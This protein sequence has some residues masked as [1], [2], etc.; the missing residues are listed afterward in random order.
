MREDKVKQLEKKCMKIREMI[1]DEIYNVGSGHV[2]GSFSAVEALVVLY[3]EIM[4]IDP[5]NP[6]MKGRDRFVLSKGHAGPAL[7]AVLADRGYFEESL[8]RTLNKPDTIL[9]SH[10]DM[11]KTPGIDMT[12]GSLGQGISCAVGMAYASKLAE[13]NAY[14]YVMVGDGECQEGQVWEAALS[15]ANLGLNNLIV[16]ID[17]NKIQLD[18]DLT[19][20][21]DM[22]NL[23]GKWREFGFNVKSIDG[24]NVSEICE[25]IIE[26]KKCKD[27]PSAIL[28][29]TIKG[30]GVSFIE[31]MGYKN[32][33]M[34][35]DDNLRNKAIREIKGESFNGQ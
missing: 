27:K 24:H 7:Y 11:N 26:C 6:R 1:I 22:G 30:K 5:Y 28:L 32:H 21:V 14:I 35:I 3:N 4:N 29:N 12:T 9:P 25:S 18:G 23:K 19:D 20:I 16:L 31:N 13:D 34:S 17:Y 33:S 10:C 8:L 15:A 2:G